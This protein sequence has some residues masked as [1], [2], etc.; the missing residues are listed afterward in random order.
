MPCTIEVP[1]SPKQTDPYDINMC[2]C[3][4]IS[5]PHHILSNTQKDLPKVL[6]HWDWIL[7]RLTNICRL[8]TRKY[9]KSRLL[10]TCFAAPDTAAFA[11][12]IEKFH[13]HVHRERWG[14]TASAVVQLVQIM[15]P[16]QHAWDKNA[17]LHG[18]HIEQRD[19]AHS[20]HVIIC[21]GSSRTSYHQ[22]QT[23]RMT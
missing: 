4:Y 21:D 17:F 22:H 6:S 9:Y 18:G 23:H 19:P 14:T 8:L 5:G 16:L 1:L 12:D 3:I 10:Q 20:C 2:H 15:H 7:A 13:G 11:T